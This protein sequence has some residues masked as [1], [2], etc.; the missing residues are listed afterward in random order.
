[1]KQLRYFMLLIAFAPELL[2]SQDA[3]LQGTDNFEITYFQLPT[4]TNIRAVLEDRYGFVWIASKGGLWRYDGGQFKNYKR[5]PKDSTSITDNNI[6]CLYE[7]K[8]GTLWVGTYGGGL[9]RYNRDCD[10]FYRY[11]HKSDDSRSISFN[12]IKVIFETSVGQLYIGTDGGGLNRMNRATG[13]FERFQF[14]EDDSLSIS[15]NNVLSLD[16]DEDGNLFVGTWFGLNIFDV[17]TSK[18]KR[19]YKDP[20]FGNQHF[21][22]LEYF[23]STLLSSGNPGLVL[24]DQNLINFGNK[25]NQILYVRE[26]DKNRLWMSDADGI[27]IFDESLK[28]IHQIP[29]TRFYEDNKTHLHLV[30]T[31]AKPNS[32]WLSGENSSFFLVEEKPEIFKPF[33]LPSSIS[34]L[35][36]TQSYYWVLVGHQLQI[37]RKSDETLHHVVTDL[38]G[39]IRFTSK[40]GNHIWVAD[41]K[42]Y[43]KYSESGQK[44]EEHPRIDDFPFTAIS[45]SGND[46]IWTGRIL[47]AD[48]YNSQSREITRFDCEPD[49]PEGIGYFHWTSQI[50]EDHLGQIW[51][52]TKG[53]GLK[54][55]DSE[56]MTF[57]H[58][59]QEIGDTTTINNNFVNEIFEDGEFNLWIG[60]NTGLCR[61]DQTDDTFVQYDFP[62]LQDKSVYAIEQDDQDNLWIGTSNGLLRISADHDEIRILNEQ[63][64]VLSNKIY[65]ASLKLDDGRLVFST[66]K[67]PMVF[68]P[69]DVK[70]STT[71][72]VAFIS[73]LLINNELIRPGSSYISKNIEV[74]ETIQM[75]YTDKK[76][77]FAL[78]VIHYKNNARCKF[79]YKLEGFDKDWI[80]AQNN[81]KATYTNIPPGN[82]TFRVKASN[83]DGIWNDQITEI[84]VIITPPIWEILW[85]RI[86]GAILIIVILILAIR[87]IIKR[88][89]AKTKFEIER[90]RVKQIEE[91]TQMKLRFFTNISHELRTPL[92]LITSPLEKYVR[93]HVAPKDTV[94]NMMYKNSTRLLELVNQVLDFRKLE[95]KQQ[96]LR[97]LPQRD[98][99]MFENIRSA[100]SYWSNDKQ[101]DFQVNTPDIKSTIHFDPDILEKI[102]TNL[103]SNAF[104]YNAKGGQVTLTAHIENI[105][106]SGDNLTKGIM[107]IK[108][109]D[110]GPGIPKDVQSKIFERFYQLSDTEVPAYGSGIGLSLTSELVSLHKGLINLESDIGKGTHFFIQIP[111]GSDDYTK[112][113]EELSVY[114]EL[115]PESTVILIVEDHEDIRNYLLE[116]LGDQYEMLEAEDGRSGLNKALAIIPD[117]IISDVM[118]PQ[119]NG[120]QMA[121]QLKNNELT[122]HIPI[123][124][125]SA[126][127]ATQHKLEGLAAG[128]SDY[129]SKP[130]NTQ[131]IK[132]KVQNLLETRNRQIEKYQK[133]GRST[134]QKTKENSYLLKINTIIQA[135]ISNSQFSV[136]TL[137]EELAIGRSQL[138]RKI[139]A[140]TGKSIIEY[141]NSYRLSIALELIKQG[142][143]SLKQ[144]AFQVGY[145]DNHYFSRSFKKEFGNPPSHYLPKQ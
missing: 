65:D 78:R 145:N 115:D 37:F 89:R 84:D 54:R 45:Q 66:S 98:L 27:S 128:A 58:Y 36:Q 64:G 126:R 67:T 132:L 118:M 9:L 97:V 20:Y 119:I 43:R 49:N 92:T 17:K 47:G 107:H 141:I 60:T 135:N 50:F 111:V 3:S 75:D 24:R 142:Q 59:R 105:E 137:C 71:K 18:S 28:K 122:A 13:E 79:R 22:C 123:L 73:E 40:D 41:G 117:V 125:L 62:E 5:D 138:Y 55:F 32:T 129:I 57:V 74:E 29:L 90:E 131:E 38:K 80:E 48:V 121:N 140:L 7:D 14:D 91:V 68:D 144:I 44:L 52:G 143:H 19:I 95:S 56:T 10:C 77:E 87:Q 61:L 139:L 96:P 136:E 4:E 46:K 8:N 33:L 85:V 109:T 112:T 113:S 81:P 94:L 1:M 25:R 114:P 51:I 103:I 35:I 16:E 26:D 70:P 116:E 86:I 31:S 83:E 134:I 76:F 63:D 101:I 15:H 104:K 88:E 110:S 100:Y 127:G 130:F 106:E 2:C 42:Y 69:E 23:N 12:E 120:I 72:P 124:F 21:F 133:E 34:S 108:V 99:A 82:Y 30:S 93:E 53:D 39:R 11:L 6:S 102:I